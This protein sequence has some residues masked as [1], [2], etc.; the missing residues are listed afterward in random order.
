MRKIILEK[1]LMNNQSLQYIIYAR[2]SQENKDRQVLSI[3]SQ[4]TEL[5]EFADKNNL[6]VVKEFQESQTAYKIGRP[7][8]A[9]M[10]ELI[11]MGVA[12]A[13][14]VWKPDRLARNAIDGGRIIQ[15]MDDNLLQ[16]IR[17]PYEIFRQTDN[18]MIVYI[19]FGMSNDYSRQ[20][21][22]NVKRGNREK[23]RRGEFVGKALLGYLN[24]DV[25]NSKNII[26]DPPKSQI[27]KKL[28]EEYSAGLYSV[29]DMVKKADVL[30]LKGIYGNPIAK[31]G[32]YKL[33]KNTAYYGL[34]KHGGEYHQGSYEPLISIDL[35][36]KVQDVL[37][38]K[39]KPRKFGW[40]NHAYKARLIKCGECGCSV[41]AET[42]RKFYKT[43]GRTG[44][45]TYYHC[46]KRRGKCSQKPVSEEEMEQ[47]LR[48]YVYRIEI[49]KEVWNLG[50]E[51]LKA[52]HSGEI[53]QSILSRRLIEKD[54][55][56][57][58]RELEKLLQLRIDQEIT[59]EE[60]SSSKKTLMDKKLLIKEKLG[61]REQTSNNWLELAENFFET[62][63]QARKIM[64]GTDLQRK[65]DLIQSVGW[66]LLLKDKKLDF[67][68]KKPY[69]I[70]L[71]PDARTS[72]QRGRDLNPR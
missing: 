39:G 25:G 22:A 35:F 18:R 29:I 50:I 5:R 42:K 51:L 4:I 38:S 1:T 64:E 49:D 40:I 36:N 53:K 16:E 65:R 47:M 62:A 10:M 63:L 2:K 43:T 34:Y 60:Y 41:T 11:E 54:Y 27:V 37:K 19:Y 3:D 21:S 32:M 48:K 69:D 59:A 66:N 12:N 71:K 20:I 61:D 23:Y 57:V 33:L 55:E 14:L 72:V 52:K 13:V 9:E 15:S 44:I 24:A 58:D 30:G 28:F 68:F 46:T 26:L 6:N 17:T 70:L 8:F 67:S 7:I 45:Y 31:S 56:K